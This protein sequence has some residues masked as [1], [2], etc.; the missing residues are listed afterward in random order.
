MATDPVDV[1]LP[2]AMIEDIMTT[3]ASAIEDIGLTIDSYGIKLFVRNPSASGD[4]PHSVLRDVREQLAGKT[5]LYLNVSDPEENYQG[6]VELLADYV[7][8]APQGYFSVES[9]RG[10]PRPAEIA[11]A[12]DVRH[13]LMREGGFVVE[14]HDDLF[15]YDTDAEEYQPLQR[16]D[17]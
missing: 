6:E 4:N 2:E 17:Y 16:D 13:A 3:A 7:S 8:T 11:A 12:S 9:V 10:S 1:E 15:Y 14:R 5:G